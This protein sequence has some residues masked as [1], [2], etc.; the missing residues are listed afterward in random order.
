MLQASQAVQDYC[1]THHVEA[2]ASVRCAAAVHHPLPIKIS[3]MPNAWFN[4]AN[5]ALQLHV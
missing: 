5:S 3:T 2:N 1:I 4:D